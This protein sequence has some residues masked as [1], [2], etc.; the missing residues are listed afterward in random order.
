MWVFFIIHFLFTLDPILI[1]SFLSPTVLPLRIHLHINH[2]P[3]PQR[4]EAPLWYHPILECLV[5]EEL[6]TS[7][8]TKAKQD[9]PIRGAGST[10]LLQLMRVLHE[11]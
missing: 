3:S 7:S 9:G 10:A 5:P 6:S 4:M 1:P 2:S 8:P 11:D